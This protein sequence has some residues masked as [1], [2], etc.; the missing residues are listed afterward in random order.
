MQITPR[1]GDLGVAVFLLA[2]AAFFIWGAL[3]MP[4]GTFAVPGPGMVPLIFGTLLALTGVS[5]IV[6]TLASRAREGAQPITFGLRVV[7]ILF[8]SLTAVAV[9][10][11]PAGFMATTVVFLFVMLRTF[12]RLDTVRS[13]LVAI[14]VALVAY[15][16]FASLLG[17][18]LPRGPWPQW[19]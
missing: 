10:F 13:L 4:A 12:S 17:V 2:V 8:G 11:E 7:A 6:K 19:T 16:F 15:G 1:N 3:R 9:A 14:A 18:T 5:L